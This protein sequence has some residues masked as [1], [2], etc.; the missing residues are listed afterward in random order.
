MHTFL[1]TLP[2]YAYAATSGLLLILTFYPF[3]LFPLVFVALVPLYFLAART[4]SNFRH[5]F[6]AGLIAFAMVTFTIAFLLAVQFHWLPASQSF[7]D[8]VRFFGVGAITLW[9]GVVF[10]ASFTL[11]RLL[12]SHSPLLNLPL[13]AALYSSAE[14]VASA[15]TGGYYVPMLAYAAVAT[16]LISMSALGGA[17][18]V[19]YI[20][21]LGN[22]CIAE[23]LLATVEQ[24][25]LV[26]RSIV[27]LFGVVLVLYVGNA[28]YLNR[29][30]EGEEHALSVASIQLANRADK[31]FA[32][33]TARGLSFPQF[34][35][36]LATIK[37]S[38]DLIIYPDSI[39]EGVI[40]R[41]KVSADTMFAAA[42]EEVQHFVARVLPN[43][44]LM[45]WSNVAEGDAIT[46]GFQFYAQGEF[47]GEQSK[48]SL[49]RFMDYT[50][51]LVRKL[52]VY[53]TPFDVVPAEE[54]PPTFVADVRMGGLVCSEAVRS[55]RA[56]AEAR[57]AE[58]LV[59]AGSEAMFIDDGIGLFTLRAL[60]YR[61]VENNIPIIR[62]SLFG[63]SALIQKDGSLT[64]Y[65]PQGEGGVLTG[66]IEVETPKQTL[67]SA[68]GGIPLALLCLT[69]FA[70][71]VRTKF[72]RRR[73]QW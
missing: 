2:W 72:L 14:V 12:R 64:A 15:T 19:S 50:P 18:F 27:I 39:V 1:T 16:P 33:T 44:A 40:A 42:G 11:Y 38:P 23:L 26:I 49:L 4:Q 71:A 51:P 32:T 45:I 41:G 9:Y 8:A 24:R 7:V 69:I 20:I 10:G 21:A 25:K 65:L 63:P 54:S 28:L 70:T 13:G 3:Y 17:F 29:E 6:F 62:M 43:S 31:E 56:R 57:G 59:A 47:V 22:I 37:N 52:G 66:E 46:T 34:E 73:E 36:A 55:G 48:E 61:A 53:V 35:A 30:Q 58:V 68:L 60:Q 67:F 5:I